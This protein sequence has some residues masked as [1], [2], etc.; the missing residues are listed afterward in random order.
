[1]AVIVPP[2]VAL[3]SPSRYGATSP[4]GSVKSH[5]LFQFIFFGF[6]G[7]EG[8][9]DFVK[10]WF[11]I[12]GKFGYIAYKDRKVRRRREETARTYRKHPE[13]GLLENERSGEGDYTG[14]NAKFQICNQ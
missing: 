3:G 14:G 8:G 11:A 2:F 13:S 5:R 6:G 10:R 1:L 4:L 9:L 12:A 7:A